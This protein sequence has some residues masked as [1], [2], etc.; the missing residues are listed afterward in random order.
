V[1]CPRV[2]SHVLG[3][4]RPRLLLRVRPGLSRLGS[5]CVRRNCNRRCLPAQLQ[6]SCLRSW[7]SLRLLLRV[8]PGLSCLGLQVTDTTSMLASHRIPTVV[9][10][11]VLV[12]QW[13]WSAV[14][15]SPVVWSAFALAVELSGLVCRRSCFLMCML[16]VTL[17]W[18]MVSFAVT[19]TPVRL[20]SGHVLSLGFAPVF[21]A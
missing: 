10:S 14:A 19:C 6:V 17:L 2:V 16:R 20:L 1:S 21:V 13:P 8:R 4:V 11:A 3:L 9:L 7:S 12:C 5:S 18:S 15:V